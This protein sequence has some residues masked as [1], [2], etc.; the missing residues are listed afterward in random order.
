M[1]YRR[2]NLSPTVVRQL[3]QKHTGAQ[4]AYISFPGGGERISALLGGHVNMMV[5]EPQEAGEHIR[6]GTLRALAFTTMA[7]AQQYTTATR[8]ALIFTLEPVIA[9]LTSWFL[10][11]ETMGLRGQV[12][13]GLILAGILLVEVRR[14]GESE[15]TG[16]VSASR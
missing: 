2:S 8:S 1:I 4:W 10:T 12:G 14:P 11:G 7:W 9:W 6:A 13:A 3:L 16:A 5:I 15:T